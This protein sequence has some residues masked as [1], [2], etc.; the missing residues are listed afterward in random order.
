[1]IPPGPRL[2]DIV[3]FGTIPRHPFADFK[4]RGL[5]AQ[6]GWVESTTQLKMLRG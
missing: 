6:T 2:N 4:V 3:F 5:R 1:M